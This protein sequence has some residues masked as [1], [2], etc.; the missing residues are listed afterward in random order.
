MKNKL[1]KFL[2]L[3]FIVA[4]ITL[5]VTYRDQLDASVI[6]NWIEEAGNAAPLLFMFVYIVGTVF[7]FPGAVLTLLGGALFGPVLGTAYNLTAA[8]IGAMLSFLVARYLASDWVEKKTGGKLKQLMN[9]VESEGWR[10]VAFVR[11]VPL[12]PFNLLNYGLGLTKIKF[13]HYS[14][15]TYIFM[16]PGA[17]AYTYLGYIGKEAAT[18]GEGLIQKAMLA[19]ALLG[20]VAFLPRIIGSIRKGAMLNVSVLKQRIDSGDDILLLDVRTAED[21][22]GEQGHIAGST[23]LPLEQ[24][25]QRI[26]E[27]NDYYEKTV[28]CICRTDRKSAKAAQILAEQGFADVHVAK[29]GMTDWIKNNY[30]VENMATD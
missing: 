18:G 7:F 2:L 24:L 23:L 5:V 3:V 9:G 21:Y 4:G 22:D 16:L 1:W 11:L 17:I 13:A 28:V 15:A 26:D 27:L 19:L 20:F 6:Q 14:I 29:M 8:T 30:P 12:F 10:F 25:E